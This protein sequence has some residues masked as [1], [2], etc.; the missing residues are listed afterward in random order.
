MVERI[1]FFVCCFMCAVPF[2]IV[3]GNQ[4]SRTPIPFWSGSESRLKEEIKDVRAYNAEMG[5]LY[6][7]V[8][9]G[10]ILCGVV[11]I[12]HFI[13]GFVA[14]GCACTLGFYVV[15]KRYERIRKKFI[16]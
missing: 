13:S 9:V 6:R 1:V 15:Y 7:M 8:A 4:A 10:F 12:I 5:R 11:G 3:S 14:L 16:R 2:L